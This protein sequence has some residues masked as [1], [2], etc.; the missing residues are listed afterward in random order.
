MA[1]AML[2][3]PVSD[4]PVYF[5]HEVEGIGD[6]NPFYE[7]GVYSVFYLKNEGRHPWWMSQS[8]NLSRW[9]PPVEAVA[10]GA[11][12]TPD[13]WTGS[14]SV[15]AD[16]AGGYRLY[17]TG[18]APDRRPKEVVMEARSAHLR[19]PWRK[20]PTATFGGA[21]Y[22]DALDFR[23]P[24]VFWNDEAK[25]W[26]MLMTTRRA[27]KA[28][29]GLL[30]SP[31]LNRWSAVPPLYT[32]TSP[33]NLEVPDLFTEGGDWF[34]LYSDQRDAARQVRYLRAAKSRGP[35]QYGPYDAL[36]GRAFYA[37]KS[38]GSGEKRLLFG[39]LA[40]RE[41]KRDD[42][43]LIWGGDMI[44]HAIRRTVDGQIAVALPESIAARFT[45]LRTKLSPDNLFIGELTRPT[46]ISLTAS[47]A[48]DARISFDFHKSTK[49]AAQLMIDAASGHA[50]FRLG[51]GYQPVDID[52]PRT[53]DGNYKFDLLVEP[54]LGLAVLY[55]NRF[56]ALS[57]RYYRVGQT[58]S[59]I[60]VHSGSPQ[61]IGTVS[62]HEK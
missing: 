33:L 20:Q 29:I 56:R 9:S 3:A 23:D 40:H 2:L 7:D 13:H 36:D 11:R 18:H 59:S 58:K 28:A 21:P 19:G 6:P 35:Y 1:F 39:W 5:A 50:Q 48:R 57:F 46:L 43:A 10:V 24:F 45:K 44:V 8:E 26:W 55:I 30:T 27:G 22:Y 38:A 60:A 25:A 53:V 14:G 34:L 4:S 17:Y 32:E 41:G 49:V 31:D 42:G 52:F 15:I 37:G 61:A 62:N 12:G 47:R 54:E 51:R 16:P